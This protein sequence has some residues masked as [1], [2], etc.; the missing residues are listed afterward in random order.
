MLVGTLVSVAADGGLAADAFGAGIGK[1][2]FD[3]LEMG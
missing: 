3:G 2:V 1:G